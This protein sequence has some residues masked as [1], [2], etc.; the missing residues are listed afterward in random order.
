M[1]ITYE[2]RTHK[3]DPEEIT[4]LEAEVIED[5]GGSRWDTLAEWY[6]L[7][8]RG[9]WRAA[10]AALWVVLMRDNPDLGYEELANVAP[11]DLTFESDDEPGK[12]TGEA[13]TEPADSA[14]D[15]PLPEQDSD[16]S[17]SN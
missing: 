14:T 12:E 3:F 1:K 13:T 4:G 17:T 8:S 10:K 7:L 15:S 6:D 5:A 9:G 11:K 16:P 2:G